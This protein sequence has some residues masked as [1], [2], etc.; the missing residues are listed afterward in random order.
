MSENTRKVTFAGSSS[1]TISADLSV[2]EIK[3]CVAEFLEVT[4]DELICHERPNG[5][6]EV[7]KVVGTKG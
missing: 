3:E 6:V 4:P 7:A 5:D 1:L 2:E